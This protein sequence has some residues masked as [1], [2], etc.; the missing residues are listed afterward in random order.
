MTGI[1]SGEKVGRNLQ[2][3]AEQRPAPVAAASPTTGK[4][5]NPYPLPLTVSHPSAKRHCG[6]YHPHATEP[7]TPPPDQTAGKA[8]A[9]DCSRSRRR[10]CTASSPTE[11]RT[12]V[13]GAKCGAGRLRMRAN[14]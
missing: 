12:K 2:T 11:N 9:M 4:L 8:R 14:S 13:P 7:R 6:N 5:Q 1:E 10:S 3:K